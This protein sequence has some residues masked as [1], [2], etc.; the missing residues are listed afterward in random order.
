MQ[1]FGGKILLSFGGIL[2]NILFFFF[3]SIGL[4]FTGNISCIKKNSIVIIKKN[5]NKFN[6]LKQEFNK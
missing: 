4:N 6:N 3:W 2:K 5:K 1:T